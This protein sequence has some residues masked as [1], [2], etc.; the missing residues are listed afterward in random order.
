MYTGRWMLLWLLVWML[1]A[2]PSRAVRL[3]DLVSEEGVRT[4]PL[5]GYGLVVGLQGT[6]DQTRQTLFTG[7]SMVNMLRQFGVQ[8]PDQA[9]PRLRNVA[10]VSVYAALPTYARS[11]QK[12]DVTVVSIGDARS[13][14]GGSL[15]TTPLRGPDGRVYAQAQGSVYV[16]GVAAEGKSGTRVSINVAT[17][18][19]I[20]EGAVIER[21]VFP[22]PDK[23]DQTRVVLNL[24]Q[25]SYRQVRA[26]VRGINQVL[27]QGTA[28]AVDG[29]QILVQTPVAPD[30]RVAFMSVLEDIEVP[31]HEGPARVVFD[32]RTGTVVIGQRVQVRPVAVSH[33]SLVVSV[34]ETPEVSQP[35]ILSGGETRV[36][37]RTG[38]GVSEQQG[39]VVALP[40]VVS[41]EE[42]TRALNTLGVTPSEM[43][44]I[45]QAMKRAG[46]L[47]AELEIL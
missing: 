39:N 22:N 15:L 31:V 40:G 12:L 16:G 5:V 9:E 13:L 17:S 41:L 11:G 14:R 4:N 6:G 1:V 24:R 44:A 20:P 47:E 43:M 8:L 35:G 30:R 19:R 45:L 33:G 10:A 25:T 36:V 32:P 3:V 26:V 29:R 46:A 37:P 21:A 7:Q 27:G 23:M 38:I 34:T 2:P 18:G 42:I 28:A